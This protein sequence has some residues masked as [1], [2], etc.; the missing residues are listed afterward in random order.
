M[1]LKQKSIQIQ[2]LRL[3]NQLGISHCDTPQIQTFSFLTCL[4]SIVLN[5]MYLGRYCSSMSSLINILI[6]NTVY[7]I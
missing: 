4:Y 5:S 7:D 6:H 1:G 2:R 3:G